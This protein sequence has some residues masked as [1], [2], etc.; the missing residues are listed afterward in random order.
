[1]SILS[2]LS[3][4]SIVFLLLAL[5]LALAFEFVNGFHDTANAVATVIYTNTLKPGYAVIWS[6][7][8]NLIGALISNGVVAFGIIAL[9]PIE[10]VIDASSAAGFAMVFA[11]LISTIIWNIGTWYLGLPVSSSHT[12]IGSI[13]GVGLM[14]SVVTG[15]GFGT[16]VNW[17]KAQ[18]VF[19]SLL[20]SP[21]IGFTAAALILVAAK[22]VIVSQELYL[23]PKLDQ[24][25]PLWIRVLLILTCAGVSFAHGSNDGQKGMGLIM[26]I[27]VGIIPSVYALDLGGDVGQLLA[28]QTS[29]TVVIAN[30][31]KI[32]PPLI[33]HQ[34]ASNQ[35]A[36]YLRTG[37]D[38]DQI[39]PALVAENK[40]IASKLHGIKTLTD[41]A[42]VDRSAL[43][44]DIYL[45]EKSISKMLKQEGMFS[46]PEAKILTNYLAQLKGATEFIPAWVKVSVAIAL[47]LGTTIGWKRIVTTVGEKIGEDH[48]TYAQGAVAELVAMSTIAAADYLGLPV[49]TT[50]VLSSGIAGAMTANGSAIQKDT[51]QGLLLA[52]ALT[53]PVCMLLGA[54]TFSIGL[55]L[56]GTHLG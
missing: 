19:A 32:N 17:V 53:L 51:V 8:W 49:S 26:L 39:F 10:L 50:H 5:L 28:A 43:R 47:G 44:T 37:M 18:E 6:G 22:A 15:V 42:A 46:N 11:L 21:L 9:L 48:L 3:T 40:A 23:A 4:G 16:G 1:V 33:D 36:E 24:A 45:V 7:T 27:L 12:L 13:L 31:A 2:D 52:W 35:L 14:N 34:S 54:I 55:C 56:T 25:P 41:I 38:R 20:I 30:H 29:V